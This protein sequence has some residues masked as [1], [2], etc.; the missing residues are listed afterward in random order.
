MP[1]AEPL[2][3]FLDVPTLTFVAV[4]LAALLG[5]FLIC[6]WMQ[7]RD[8]RALAWWGSAYLIGAAAMT[9]WGAQTPLVRVPP[10]LPGAL[11][12]LACGVIWNG[13][14][15]FHGRRLMPLAASTGAFAWLLLYRLPV[16]T[17]GPGGSIGLGALV[18]ACYTFAIAWELWRER[19]KSMF[20]RTAAVVVPGLHAAVFLLPFA[21]QSVLPERS[22]PDWLTVLTL[23]TIIYAVG[24]AFIVLLMVKDH[25]VRIYRDA[26]STDHLTGLLNRRAFLENARGL[27]ERQFARKAPV[28]L[29][30]FD[31]DHFKSI[32]D[33]FG[34][35][36]G[37]EALRVFAQV[38][39]TSTRANDIVGRLG[40]EEF[41]AIV[42]GGPDVAEIVGERLRAAFEKAGET[43]VS[44][45]IGATV[46]IG[47]ATA[48]GA[49]V[50]IDGL[51]ARA[52]A[53]LYQAKHNG[54]NRM[55]AAADEVP[56]AMPAPAAPVVTLPP[57]GA[58]P[59]RGQAVPAEGG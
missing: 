56:T 11:F 38:A 29:M 52:D 30:M 26:A 15:L 6:V 22:A 4:C 18:V 17:H 5:L 20:S 3:S 32:N 12:F 41:A 7:Q 9:L 39:R 33:R 47:A 42:P 2:P 28:T 13:V 34:H 24:T 37:D 10:E 51:L 36:V 46:S 44:H 16:T 27:C 40:G 57:A 45:A 1:A 53:A 31:L 25:H 49:V 19:R 23:E 43:I 54:R 59:A 58:L 8:A 21:L 48:R 35:A 55:V 14:R 50:D